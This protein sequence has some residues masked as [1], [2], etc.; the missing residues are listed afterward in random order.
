MSADQQILDELCPEGPR[1]IKEGPTCRG[2][3]F[4][5]EYTVKA[6][7]SKPRGSWPV[8]G[9]SYVP[10]PISKHLVIPGCYMEVW[11][12]RGRTFGDSISSDVDEKDL[13]DC[14]DQDREGSC[15]FYRA[16]GGGMSLEAAKTLERR[17]SEQKHLSET[18]KISIIALVISGIA[19]VAAVA[20]QLHLIL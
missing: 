14:L 8:D 13:D 4:L 15:F 5:A 17:Q 19:A 6:D 20:S 12:M 16:Q 11:K 7:G 18:R 2:C 9:R 10:N 1:P 3:H